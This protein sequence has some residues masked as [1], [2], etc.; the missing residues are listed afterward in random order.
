MKNTFS[1]SAKAQSA[2]EYLTTYGWAIL[3]I[4]VVLGALFELGVFSGYYL[5]PKLEPGSCIVSRPY[6]P[7][8]LQGISL[9]GNCGGEIP[10][11][12]YSSEYGSAYIKIPYN[13][14]SPLLVYNFTISL[15]LKEYSGAPNISCCSGEFLLFEEPDRIYIYRDWEP[16][17]TTRV[18]GYVYNSS[19]FVDPTLPNQALNYCGDYTLSVGTNTWNYWAFTYNGTN[20]TGYV[21]GN[22][23]CTVKIRGVINPIPSVNYTYIGFVNGSEANVQVY[24]SALTGNYIYAEYLQGIGGAPINLDKLVAWYPLN[25]NAN[26]YS[27][28]GENG[29]VT[30]GIF[31]NAWESGYTQP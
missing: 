30:S 4:A 29:N 9:Q 20:L 25:G 11:Y 12:T 5:A 28:N 1:D 21:N 24:D 15:W 13:K 17:H 7:R 2:M 10:E 8:S 16:A 6:G 19:I 26:D 14:N 22:K 18:T 31:S 27:G 3:I 23:F